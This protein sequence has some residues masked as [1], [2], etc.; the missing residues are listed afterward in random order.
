MRINININTN[1]KDVFKILISN[2]SAIQFIELY[3]I[4]IEYMEER[5]NA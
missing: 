4:M 3:K 1:A 2:L 5:K